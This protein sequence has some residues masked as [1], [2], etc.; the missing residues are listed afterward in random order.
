MR[1]LWQQLC[2]QWWENNREKLKADNSWK[3]TVGGKWPYANDVFLTAYQQVVLDG[4][5][6][7]Y[8]KTQATSANGKERA[9]YEAFVEDCNH[10]FY[11]WQAGR[12]S[13]VPDR[14]AE[15]FSV[16]SNAGRLIRLGE[17]VIALSKHIESS[18]DY[19]R[20]TGTKLLD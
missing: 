9:I 2:A 1:L 6:S 14:D 5:S 11:Q 4:K 3:P 17:E 20:S 16:T 13:L 12:R 10:K 18:L 15:W 19:S 8:R 7:L